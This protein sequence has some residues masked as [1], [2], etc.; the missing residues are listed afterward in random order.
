MNTTTLNLPASNPVA[1][2]KLL[3]AELLTAAKTTL[4]KAI[5]I[6]ELLTQERDRLRHGEW[7]SWVRVNLPFTDR[8][9]RN[10]LQVFEQ[11]DR[12][13][14]ESVSDLSDAYRLLCPVKPA[15][16]SSEE[17]RNPRRNV[18]I[19]VPA[20]ITLGP[21]IDQPAP[22]EPEDK[23]RIK[24][25]DEELSEQ[26]EPEMTM[27]NGMLYADLAI[28]ELK[29]MDPNDTEREPAFQAVIEWI[30]GQPGSKQAAPPTKPHFNKPDWYRKMTPQRRY[31]IAW[32]IFTCLDKLNIPDT[33]K[34]RKQVLHW[35]EQIGAAE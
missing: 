15:D 34:F 14:L 10:Y 23:P 35:M 22:I 33:K 1:E 18:E 3:H 21:A 19:P 32:H 6:G 30:Y 11:R 17:K 9:A 16:F 25:A 4:E 8:T 31:A 12:L 2:I 20:E 7:L 29:K 27:S 13:K 24:T 28:M 26:P 5:R